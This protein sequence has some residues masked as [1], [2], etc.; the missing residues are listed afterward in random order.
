MFYLVRHGNTDYSLQNTRIY[1][2][3]G[4]NLSP[5]S[6]EGIE[7]IQIT[8]RDPRLKDAD[9]IL[10]SPYTRALQTAAILSKNLGVDI[11]VETDLHEWIANKDYI[12]EDDE[13][14]IN[15]YREYTE[16]S[17]EHKEDSK[18][19]WETSAD[20]RARVIPVLE[21][22][23][24]LDKVVVACH[25]TLIQAITGGHLPKNGEIVEF[26]L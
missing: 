24:H 6:K 9:L 7:Q 17:G 18:L 21:K 4:V 23:K 26:E 16:N 11:T 1:Q 10:S 25:G 12:Y 22:Y 2:G 5:L 20:I 14:A 13:T 8:S 15:A 3:Y 19:N